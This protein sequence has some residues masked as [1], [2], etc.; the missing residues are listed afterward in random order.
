MF[1]V[2]SLGWILWIFK[3]VDNVKISIYKCL[4][5]FQAE[6]S[7]PRTQGNQPLLQDGNHTCS[8]IEDSHL[9]SQK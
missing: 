3:L 2:L 8:H 7:I 1:Q 9:S 6:G 5:T 4:H